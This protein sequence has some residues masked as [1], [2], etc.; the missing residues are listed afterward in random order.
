MILHPWTWEFFFL[1]PMKKENLI[2][3]DVIS[4][5]SNLEPYW[6]Q[7]SLAA[8]IPSSPIGNHSLTT[9][10]HEDHSDNNQST[11]STLEFS[12]DLS[13][14][15]SGRQSDSFALG[16]EDTSHWLCPSWPGT[17]LH[18]SIIC[19]SIGL[20]VYLYINWFVFLFVYQ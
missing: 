6:K 5:S 15:L 18:T 13:P 12:L 1:Q 9:I 4:F 8:S 11:S 3:S 19:K 20:F 10:D 2:S 7:E 16:E 14:F 17:H